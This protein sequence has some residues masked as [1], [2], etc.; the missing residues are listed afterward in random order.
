MNMEIKMIDSIEW[1][2]LKIL[3]NELAVTLKQQKLPRETDLLTR[4]EAAQE[5]RMSTRSLDKIKEDGKIEYVKNGRSVAFLR[6]DVDGYK[7]EN[8]VVR[9]NS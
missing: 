6:K 4:K 1:Q 5:L 7:I 9:K 8:R 2:G 3:M